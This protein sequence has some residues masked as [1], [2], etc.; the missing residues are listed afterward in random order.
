VHRH[1]FWYWQVRSQEGLVVL[2]VMLM[3]VMLVMLLLLLPCVPATPPA[4]HHC[5]DGRLLH[6]LGLRSGKHGFRR[7]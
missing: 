6:Q 4:I 3:L 7:L 1:R 5:S 2:L